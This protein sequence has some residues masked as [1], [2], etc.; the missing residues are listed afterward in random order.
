MAINFDDQMILADKVLIEQGLYS[1]VTFSEKVGEEVYD[2]TTGSY[3]GGSVIGHSF[4]AVL[5]TESSSAIDGSGFKVT[6]DIVIIARNIT[7]TPIVDQLFVING[8]QWQLASSKMEPQRTVY[9]I[10]LG[11]K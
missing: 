3:Q 8:T 2:P 1:T 10:T 4:N 6:M 9:E 7:F 5:L 11:R